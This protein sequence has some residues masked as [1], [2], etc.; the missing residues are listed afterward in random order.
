MQFPYSWLKTQVNTS[1]PPDELA[2]LLTMAGLE[3]EEQAPAAPPFSQVVVAEVKSVEKHPDADRL[4]I[5]QVDAGTGEC[6]QIVCGA[7]NVKAGIK[8]PCALPGAVLPG[9][10]KIK[11]TKMR[12][13][14][15]NGM[16]CSARE[17]GLPED[18]D[19]LLILP[20]DAP[21]GVNLRDYLN[22]D[23]TV[24]TLKI[25]P[26]RADCLSIRG[27]ARE[28][29][30]LGGAEVSLP[31]T[32]AVPVKSAAVQPVHIEAQEDCGRFL[33]RVIEGVNAQTATPA[34]MRERLER[35]G[36][37]SVSALVDIGNYVMLETGQPMHVFDAARLSGS[38]NIRR[39]RAGETLAC[40]NGK[41]VTLQPD[42]L[43]VADDTA[44]LSLA[45]LMGGKAS[46]VDETTQNIVLECA[47]FTPH[48]IAGKSRQYG[49]GSDSSFRYERGVDYELQHEALERASALI[50]DICGGTA[51]PVT[52]A[53]GQL[54][55]SKTVTLRM[56]RIEK[57][58][59]IAI[60]RDTVASILTRLQLSP[61][62]TEA[63][64]A[65]TAPSFR[66]DIAIEEDLI[67]EIGRVYGYDKIPAD[68]A[69]ARIQML[70]LPETETPRMAVYRQMAAAGFQEV[71]NY[72]FVDEA[73][74]QD[75]SQ[76]QHPIRLKNP[77]ASQ[78]SVMRSTL[79]G[80]LVQTLQTNL[81]RKQPRVRVFEIARTFHTPSHGS[82]EY[83]QIERLAALAYGATLPEQWGCP[84]RNVDFY[85]LKAD[86]EQLLSG[87]TLE[88]RATTHPA[89]HPGRCAQILVE[90]SAAGIIGQLHPKWVQKYD[91]PQAP[92]LFELELAPVL[93]RQAVRYQPIS[94]LQPV[95][96]DLAFIVPE[97]M[98]FQTLLETLRQA[99]DPLVKDIALFDIYRGT[100]LPENSKSMA[101][102]AVVQ[103]TEQNLTDA[104]VEE[105]IAKLIA[106]AAAIGAQLR[107]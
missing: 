93:H 47:W 76:N 27:L 72:A 71:V 84:N 36:M 17:L 52:E 50:L 33:S 34:W 30:A 6:I 16:L 102:K 54:P 101:V 25:T 56:E 46:S 7:P 58:L 44:T 60:D 88:F 103:E 19:G 51:G 107:S 98:T 41:T 43:V 63:G 97:A 67:E 9:D 73:W 45:G 94:R 106:A 55:H 105:I 70:R 1:L 5:T 89:L 65:V 80:G 38:L 96:R 61:V 49:F 12:G 85:D 2:H 23:D 82:T 10:F 100:G 53:L 18:V 90:G 99:A 22:L 35:S 87:R 66:Y 29:G 21:T 95:R 62:A 77:I 37:R 57:V 4:N 48:I 8:V 28:V 15:S 64:F 78:M 75:F 104:I 92:V 91:L 40:L 26:N 11:P 3:V 69:R 20:E 39:A 59:G 83:N 81:N 13:Q 32:T 14:V 24:F 79:I 68:A 42:T 31:E 74:E 86:V